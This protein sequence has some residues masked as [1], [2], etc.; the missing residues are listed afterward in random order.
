MILWQMTLTAAA[1]Y[2]SVKSSSGGKKEPLAHFL[3]YFFTFIRAIWP[4]LTLP[5]Q[6]MTHKQKHIVSIMGDI[7]DDHCSLP[8]TLHF[9]LPAH[10]SLITSLIDAFLLTPPVSILEAFLHDVLAYSSLSC[11]ISD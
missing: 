8:T 7:M 11:V 1:G 5:V 6:F 9:H 4:Q 10:F 3:F 2:L